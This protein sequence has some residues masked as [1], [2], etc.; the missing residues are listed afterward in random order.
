MRSTK[1][2]P[3]SSI[4][5]ITIVFLL[6]CHTLIFNASFVYTEDFSGQV[7]CILDGDTLMR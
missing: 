5:F 2:S 3:L 4:G 7:V 1:I 6:V